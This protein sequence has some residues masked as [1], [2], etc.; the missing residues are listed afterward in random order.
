MGPLPE[1]AEPVTVPVLLAPWC[2]RPGAP[3]PS[4]ASK[5]GEREENDKLGGWTHVVASMA[6]QNH[7]TSS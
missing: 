7:S 3:P 1:L 2:R 6:G 5:A 4:S